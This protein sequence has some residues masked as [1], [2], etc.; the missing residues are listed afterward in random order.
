M[1]LFKLPLFVYEIENRIRIM[2]KRYYEDILPSY[3][4]QLGLIET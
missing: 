3:I 2:N 1:N 4:R